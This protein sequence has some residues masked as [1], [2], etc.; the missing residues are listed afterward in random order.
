MLSNLVTSI[1]D[2]ILSF[3]PLHGLKVELKK[4]EGSE[5]GLYKSMVCLT[6]KIYTQMTLEDTFIVKGQGGDGGGGS[7]FTDGIQKTVMKVIMDPAKNEDS[8]TF[9]EISV[10][11]P[12]LRQRLRLMIQCF[13]GKVKSYLP[14]LSN[15]SNWHV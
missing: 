12:Q 10:A 11:A 2:T 7:Y 15:S 8:T 9:S 13:T 5:R 4:S 14:T 3:T 1:L 6:P